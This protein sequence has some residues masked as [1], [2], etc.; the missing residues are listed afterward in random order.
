MNGNCNFIDAQTCV[1][2]IL[3]SLMGEFVNW[4]IHARGVKLKLNF[5]WICAK[6]ERNALQPQGQVT[7]TSIY[8]FRKDKNKKA[9]VL[10]L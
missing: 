3:V 2:V 1:T 8:L 5:I 4:T 6:A 7:G 9:M 10:S